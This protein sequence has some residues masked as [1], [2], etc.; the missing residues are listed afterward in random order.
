MIK[1][2]AVTRFAELCLNLRR[3]LR[4]SMVLIFGCL[5]LAAS[6]M[7]PGDHTERVRAFTR[8]IEF[9]YLGWTL[10]AMRFKFF[11]SAL[12]TGFYLSLDTRRELV[13]EYLQLMG[14]IQH[15]ENQLRAIY[16]DPAISDPRTAS[17]S[18]R[19][20]LNELEARRDQIAPVAESVLQGQISYMID[21]LDLSLGGQAIPPVMYHS[22]PL[23]LALV[24]SPREVIRLDENVSLVPELSVSEQVELE[25]RVDQALDVSSLVVGIGGIGTYPTMVQ[26]TG[27]LDWLS[28]V[29]A[30]EWVHNF[31]TLRPLGANYLTSPDLRVMNETTASIAGKEIGRAVLEVY[32]PELLPP[33]PPDPEGKP[34]KPPEPPAFDFREEMHQTRITVDALLAEGKVEQAEEYME[35]RRRVFLEN[36]YRGLRKLNQAYFAFHGAYADE[37]GGAAG[38]KEDPIGAAVRALRAKSPSLAAFLNRMSWMQSFEQLQRAVENG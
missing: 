26:Q 29:I 30:H 7:V 12:G 21:V 22:T 28:E 1:S 34:S 13:M 27:S 24:V 32:Y 16:A 11:E 10:N 36:G 5:V 18:L 6:N 15:A 9:D 31:L 4:V 3:W 33:P 17:L 38:E 19:Q 25:E 37:P 35:M 2:A 23:P 14:G 8:D 20:E